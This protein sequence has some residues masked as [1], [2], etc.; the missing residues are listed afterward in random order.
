MFRQQSVNVIRVEGRFSKGRLSGVNHVIRVEG[1]F[2]KGRLRDVNLT[3]RPAVPNC[4][5]VRTLANK[6]SL[7][8]DYICDHNVVPRENVNYTI[9]TFCVGESRCSHY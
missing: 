7:R 9:N 2:S 1:R 4:D 6:A 3:F 8:S 5:G